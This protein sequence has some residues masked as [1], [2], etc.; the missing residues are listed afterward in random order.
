VIKFAA[1]RIELPP[2][3]QPHGWGTELLATPDGEIVFL[4][5][6]KG[7]R[8]N[9]L[10]VVDVVTGEATADQSIRG[11][12]RDAYF[13]APDH[14]WLLTTFALG[15]LALEDGRLTVTAQS[16]PRGLGTY[17]HRLHPLGKDHLLVSGRGSSSAVV[18]ERVTGTVVRRIRVRSPQLS[19]ATG[20]TVRFYATRDGECVD[21]ALPSMKVSRAPMVTGTAPTISGN[22]LVMLEGVRTAAVQSGKASRIEPTALVALSLDSLSPIRRGP[23]PTGA[24][25]VLGVDASGRI[26][27]STSSG[28]AL[29][30]RET[31]SEVARYDVP[32][33]L[34]PIHA[35]RWLGRLDRVA[36]YARRLDAHELR[37][38]GW[39]G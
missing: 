14:G 8:A 17:R 28:I 20:D 10:C 12:L 7:R 25:D 1:D 3:E 38:I 22:E 24:R 21:V 32:E 4:S 6:P 33:P 9:R 13:E 30:D 15:E 36:V 37:L 29:A 27:V 19:A 23:A 34:R 2:F 31:F 5:L 16:R 39:D 35:H 18:V 26:V 11:D